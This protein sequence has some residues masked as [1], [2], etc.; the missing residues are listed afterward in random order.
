ML[1]WLGAWGGVH[2]RVRRTCMGK[3]CMGR[4]IGTCTGRSAR[5]CI[6]TSMSMCV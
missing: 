3:E 5:A 2:G 1:A 6:V 4:S